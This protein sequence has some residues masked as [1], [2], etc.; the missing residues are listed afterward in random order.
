MEIIRTLTKLFITRNK[1][2]DNIFYLKVIENRYKYPYR[3]VLENVPKLVGL[4]SLH[5]LQNIG[6]DIVVT[7]KVGL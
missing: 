6:V 2:Q 4:P 5:F 3:Y 7:F 1:L